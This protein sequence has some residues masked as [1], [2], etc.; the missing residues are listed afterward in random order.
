MKTP[1]RAVAAA[2]A[3]LAL[4]ACSHRGA[5]DSGTA[6]AAA[7]ASQPSTSRDSDT[8]ASGG[9]MTLL[10][11]GNLIIQVPGDAVTGTTT[12]YDDGM[13]QTYYD[14]RGSIPLTVAVE[15]YAAGAKP[16][17]SI[18]AAEQQALT[19]QSIQPTV[20]PVKVP[21]GSGANRLDWQTTAIPPWLQDRKTAEV[22]ITCAGII[23]DGP[24]G[25][26][27]GVYVFADPKN[28]ESLNRMSSV[29]T[30]VAVSAS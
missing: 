15:Y 12:T 30:S 4:C 17:A 16:A 7:S 14:S 24:S 18:L 8:T 5:S 3:I 20:T 22:P 27:Y 23:V 6:S 13:Q 1:V 10:P 21:G 29:L 19:A 25:E 28:K 26:S 9:M 2:M 11:T